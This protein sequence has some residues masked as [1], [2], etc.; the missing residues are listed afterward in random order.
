MKQICFQGALCICPAGEVLSNDT[1]TCEDLNECEP[2]G[3]C[4]QTCTN[5]KK[6]FVCSC[7]KGYELEFDNRTCKAISKFLICCGRQLKQNLKF[8]MKY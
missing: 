5:I 3:V 7:V 2:P 4:S 8:I 6:G 1:V